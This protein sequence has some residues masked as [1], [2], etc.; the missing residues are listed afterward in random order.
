MLSLIAH[1]ANQFGR[2]EVRALLAAKHKIKS[3]KIL[4][5]DTVKKNAFSW[6]FMA[7]L[8]PWIVLGS[9]NLFGVFKGRDR[10]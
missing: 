2:I 8:L 9:K 1:R 6:P 10:D 7:P 4:G 5:M 3:Y